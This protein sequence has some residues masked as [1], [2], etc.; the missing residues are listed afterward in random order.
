[1]IKNKA[2]LDSLDYTLEQEMIGI[3]LIF[4]K[5]KRHKKS[6]TQVYFFSLAT[7]VSFIF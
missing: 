4:F 6:L 3:G 7:M 5:K 2:T 1:M